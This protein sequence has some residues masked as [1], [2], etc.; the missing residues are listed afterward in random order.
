MTIMDSGCSQ[1]MSGDSNRL[2]HKQSISQ[3]TRI[4]SFTGASSSIDAKGINS[5][6]LPEFY[7]RAMPED[8]TLLSANA[9]AQR[10]AIVLLPEH[11]AVY[12]LT[13]AQ[14]KELDNFL[15]KYTITK[16]LAG[17]NR[18]YA[19]VTERT[20]PQDHVAMVGNT[21]FNT[22]VNVTNGEERILAY[23]LMGFTWEMPHHAATHGNIKGL[24]PDITLSL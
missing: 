4:K 9:Y 21:Y 16:Q 5:D 23:M 6:N 7:V 11:G 15:S 13:K 24:H 18:V 19:I 1:N 17:K 14:R 8:L 2:K 22:K 10:G 3:D 12:E 20:P